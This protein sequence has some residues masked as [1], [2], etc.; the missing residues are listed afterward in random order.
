MPSWQSSSCSDVTMILS[1]AQRVWQGFAPWAVM[2]ACWA[3][4]L[5]LVPAAITSSPGFGYSGAASAQVLSRSLVVAIG[6]TALATAIGVPVALVMACTDVPARGVLRSLAIA[7]LLVPPYIATIGWLHLLG[8]RGSW[9]TFLGRLLNAEPFMGFL[10]PFGAI[11]VLGLWGYPLIALMAQ[12]GLASLDADLID[13][14][15]LDGGAKAVLR[16]VIGPALVPAVAAAALVLVLLVLGDYGVCSFL[17]VPV[18]TA[19]VMLRFGAFYD[20]GGGMRALLPLAILSAVGLLLFLRLT[21]RQGATPLHFTAGIRRPFSLGGCRWPAFILLLFP[22][23]LAT[24]VPLL[25]LSFRAPAVADFLAAWS[26]ARRQIANTALYGPLGAILGCLLAW[27]VA[28]LMSRARPAAAGVM[29]ALNVALLVVPGVAVGM[30]LIRLFNRGGWAGWV[31]GSP[32]MVLF[33]MA[34]RALPLAALALSSGWRRLP[35]EIEEAAQVAGASERD[36]SGHIRLPLLRSA[37]GSA[38]ALA[39]FRAMTELEATVLVHAP[40]DDTLAV[41]LYTLQHDGLAEHVAALALSLIAL[42]VL[43]SLGAW[44]LARGR[45]AT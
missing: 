16:G 4:M 27:P 36:L 11:W 22:A 28:R 25:A 19:Q 15:I 42:A 38:C 5:A 37:M 40:G 1:R 43:G 29:Q 12:A 6:S 7:P 32:L 33:C 13:H 26:S 30:G 17:G 10:S 35:R 41:R 8:P 24:A 23:L 45:G 18:Y 39:C 21:G 31:Y 14:A 9:G 2:C 20:V 3:P 44:A 34:L